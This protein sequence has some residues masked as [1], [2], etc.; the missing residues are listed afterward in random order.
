MIFLITFQLIECPSIYELMACPNFQWKNPP[1][2]EIWREKHDVDGNSFIM[3]E[4]YTP[5]EGISIIEESLLSN[6][7]SVNLNIKFNHIIVFSLHSN[8]FLCKNCLTSL[9]ARLTMQ[10]AVCLFHS[11]G[12][13]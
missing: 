13:F 5:K 11:T 12:I 2:L 8:V 1:R 4:P 9:P 3:L 7:V 6:T 10:V